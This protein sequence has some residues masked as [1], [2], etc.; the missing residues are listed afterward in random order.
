MIENDFLYLSKHTGVERGRIRKVCE[1]FEAG[2]TVPFVA[3]YRKEATGGL[4]EVILIKIR[5][6]VSNLEKLH[7][8]RT[9]ILESLIERGILTDELE[10]KFNST[11]SL[12]ELEDFYLPFKQKRKTRASAAREKGLEPL[13]EFIIAQK[14]GFM[15]LKQFINSEKGLADEAAAIGGAMDILA[16]EISENADIRKGLRELFLRN[17][18]LA[19]KAVKAKMEEASV[20]RDYFDYS[21]A[22]NRVPSH[23]AL[24]VMRG[25]EQGFLSM[26]LRPEKEDALRLI[27]GAVIRNRAFT[28]YR[29]LEEMI[30]D[31]YTRLLMPSMENES[32]NQL[33][34]KA[35]EEAIAVFVSNLKK[36]LLEAPLGQKRI[37]AVDPGFRTGC[38]TVI[39]DA[40]GKLIEHFVIYPEKA[41]AAAASILD[42]CRKYKTEAVAVGN[43]TAGRET[44]DFL[45]KILP[46]EI[47]VI[48]VNESGASIYSAGEVARREFPDL[49]LTFRSAASIGRRLQ[50]PL[51]ELIKID[52]KSIG[53]GQYQHDVEQDELKKSLDDA[54][55]ACVNSV[56][57]ELNT[58]SI[59]L[60]SYVSGLNG[61]LAEN[62][63]ACRNANGP[64][65]GR[66]ALKKVKGL[67]PKAFE[68]CAGFLR[69]RGAVNP[70]DSSGV[71]PERYALVGTMAKDYDCTVSE[72]MEKVSEGTRISPERYV[73]EQTGLPTIQDILK[74][75]AKPGR[76]PRPEFKAFSFSENVH[77]IEDLSI[78]MK[79]PGIVTNV[80]KF[81]AFIDIGV[82]NDGLLHIS[83]MADRYIRDPQEVVSVNDR[84]TVTVTEIDRDRKRISLS[85]ID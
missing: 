32:I 39:L 23:R 29:Q 71:H 4:D 6:M 63:I 74:E 13:A 55:M 12:D 49:D 17:G 61:R 48:S 14:N 53:V 67:G 72:L 82:H 24:A 28:Y 77:S 57:V 37:I 81:G 66:D 41:D 69:I 65:K 1:L 30:E 38:K 3:R 45:R 2:A 19:S 46:A 18:R 42:A 25:H 36:L 15:D 44:E 47:P 59:E 50:D 16:E 43:G 26:Q 64:F 51:A 70:L 20:Y 68:Q 31:A 75:L 21:E 58:A 7:K 73:N 60:L 8:R 79:L 52:P 84:L 80:T 34:R 33:K 11:Y 40:Q 35:D 83:K 62:I 78:G 22:A 27:S 56:G 85:L 5:D 76:D 10:N 54:V 9:N